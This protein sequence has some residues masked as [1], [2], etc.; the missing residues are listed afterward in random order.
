M[1]STGVGGIAL[2]IR[3]DPPPVL[4]PVV[5]SHKAISSRPKPES[6]IPKAI[7]IH[8]SPVEKKADEVKSIHTK[9]ITSMATTASASTVTNAPQLPVVNRKRKKMKGNEKLKKMNTRDNES[10]KVIKVLQQ[11]SEFNFRTVAKTLVSYPSPIVKREFLHYTQSD[12]ITVEEKNEWIKEVKQLLNKKSNKVVPIIPANLQSKLKSLVHT[13][14]ALVGQSESSSAQHLGEELLSRLHSSI[15]ASSRNQFGISHQWNPLILGWNKL[16]VREVLKGLREQLPNKAFHDVS[17]KPDGTLPDV[18][19]DPEEIVEDVDRPELTFSDSDFDSDDEEGDGVVGTRGR[20]GEDNTKME[21]VESEEEDVED[22]DDDDDGFESFE[23][24]L[25]KKLNE[26]K[27]ENEVIPSISVLPQQPVSPA[28]SKSTSVGCESLKRDDILDE[29]L[30]AREFSTFCVSYVFLYAKFYLT[31][32][33]GVAGGSLSTFLDELKSVVQLPSMLG[34]AYAFLHVV[35]DFSLLRTPNH[36]YGK[37]LMMTILG[38]GGNL[39]NKLSSSHGMESEVPDLQTLRNKVMDNIKHVMDMLRN[40]IESIVNQEEMQQ[41]LAFNVHESHIANYFHQ[42]HNS[43]K[44]N[45][46]NDIQA[47]F[48]YP[49]DRDAA[50]LLQSHGLLSVM[51]EWLKFSPSS[52]NDPSLSRSIQDVFGVKRTTEVVSD[53][54]LSF[55]LFAKKSCP[56][57]YGNIDATLLKLTLQMNSLL[58]EDILLPLQTLSIQKHHIDVDSQRRELDLIQVYTDRFQAMM[59]VDSTRSK[60]RMQITSLDD[61]LETEDELPERI[62][63]SSEQ[64][65]S[66][67]IFKAVHAMILGTHLYVIQPLLGYYDGRNHGWRCGS[68]GEGLKLAVAFV[69]RSGVLRDLLPRLSFQAK[70]PSIIRKD[71]LC[72]QDYMESSTVVYFFQFSSVPVDDIVD[73][74]Y[75]LH[76]VQQEILSKPDRLHALFHFQSDVEINVDTLILLEKVLHLCTELLHLLSL[77]YLE[78]FLHLHSC[79]L[80]GLLNVLTASLP[81][82]T[83]DTIAASCQAIIID[84]SIRLVELPA[85]LGARSRV[86]V[87]QEVYSAMQ[88]LPLPPYKIPHQWLRFSRQD[89]TKLP[90]F[91]INLDRRPDRY[92]KC[93]CQADIANMNLVRI[94]AVDGNDSNAQESAIKNMLKTT[95]LESNSTEITKATLANISHRDIANQWNTSLN[96]LFDQNCPKNIDVLLTNSEKACAA[97]HLKCWR[98][99]N[100]L[101]ELYKVSYRKETSKLSTIPKDKTWFCEEEF[102]LA[103]DSWQRYFEQ[104]QG[105]VQMMYSIATT[106]PTT[107]ASKVSHP[108]QYDDFYLICE[109]DVHIKSYIMPHF[110]EEIHKIVHRA[111]HLDWDIIYLGAA[112]PSSSSNF[113]YSIVKNGY[114]MKVNYA[115]MLHGYILRGSSAS[116]LLSRLPIVGPVD[117]FIARLIYDNE[118]NVSL[119]L[120]T[121]CWIYLIFSLFFIFY[122]YFL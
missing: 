1:M 48:T 84:I 30:I 12:L 50:I 91:L 55:D 115:W 34:L 68:L 42:K 21:L 96:H 9:N 61:L 15:T 29:T 36:A 13:I 2:N 3:A 79:Q 33:P 53:L 97:S 76:Y 118:I 117:N 10:Q 113:K 37:E 111:K 58:D 80:R 67:A 31:V 103:R 83:N 82:I 5:D 27:L 60:S 104:Y 93:L 98:Y 17:N 120:S 20:N 51:K 74:C 64:I 22:D 100:A 62:G 32:I 46:A 89:R 63:L 107:T 26:E 106:N 7:S 28:E 57:D 6:I 40:E 66:N 92:R 41:C 38:R 19:L 94:N 81:R 110:R 116:K 121:Y 88:V 73:T 99:I 35:R 109:D 72:P 69:T 59:K 47:N 95:F 18:K 39:L 112:L 8:R 101:H 16:D 11:V 90:A 65:D 14:V 85:P 71:D 108:N 119:L 78:R 4:L 105:V 25:Q 24:L 86:E 23:K 122:F 45:C 70:S 49:N 77:S 87:K 114:F 75:L 52:H 54:L 102:Q 56:A 44:W 43:S